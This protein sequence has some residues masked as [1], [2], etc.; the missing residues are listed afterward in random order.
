MSQKVNII[1]LPY[2]IL[3]SILYEAAKLQQTE[4]VV[5]TFGLS[6]LPE[7]RDKVVPTKP[8]KYIKGPTAPY[9][10]RWDAIANLR[11]VCRDWH[12]WALD[13]ALAD[14][15]VKLWRGSER[16]C[17]LTTQRDKYP[18][19]EMVR[20]PKGEKVYRDPY[21]TLRRTKEFM[22]S[23]PQ[24][25]SHVTRLWFNGLYVPT[26]DGDVTAVIRA[27]PNLRNV[28]APWTLL[29]HATANDW[30]KLLLRDSARPLE[31]L[32][33]TA[34][35]LSQQ[36]KA[37]FKEAPLTAPLMSWSVD[38]G[39]LKRL[40][41]F[42]NTDVLP[43]CDDDLRMIARTATHLEEFVMTCIS[44]VTIE[45]VMAIVRS[46]A[47][48]LRVLE[49]S[50]RSDDGFFHPHPGTLAS[51]EHICELLTACPNLRDVSISIPTMCP[52]LFANT[53]VRWRGDCQVRALG[54][55]SHGIATRSSSAIVA[56]RQT[57]EQARQL[58]HAR[59]AGT[60]SEELRL[61]LFF[62]D[63]IFEPHLEIVHG[64]FTEAEE[65]TG[66]DWPRQQLPSRKGPYGSTG[67]YEKQDESEFI[68]L[69]EEEL[70]AGMGMGL[71]RF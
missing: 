8:Q 61:E 69:S 36:Q 48:T 59:A 15:Y 37:E 63:M 3:S 68:C 71:V 49:H 19:Y 11:L 60:L 2:E 23:C 35:K 44:T 53:G 38:F 10:L 67:L 16:W 54:L 18:L 57:L 21:S 56:L 34:T 32:E 25:A 20:Y 43:V 55:C 17:D 62:A 33:L 66:G 12:D 42:G 70:F 6:Q 50:P 40:K 5:F 30:E 29:R 9:Q 64:D 58:V 27:C 46:S 45:G 14:V 13:Y 24:A 22:E 28:S 52:A 26:S 1:S 65:M 7:C 31:S 51:G 41:L 39:R 47:R 4:N